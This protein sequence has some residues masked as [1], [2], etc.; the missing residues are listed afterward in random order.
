MPT[1]PVHG[2]V[3]VSKA[4]SQSMAA[5]NGGKSTSDVHGRSDAHGPVGATIDVEW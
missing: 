5:C 3:S 2:A 4:S 1:Q